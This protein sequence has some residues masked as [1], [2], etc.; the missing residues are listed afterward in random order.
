MLSS[1]INHVIDD[2]QGIEEI[3]QVGVISDFISCLCLKQLLLK[4]RER[5]QPSG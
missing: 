1:D 2:S 3:K 5:L 4:I